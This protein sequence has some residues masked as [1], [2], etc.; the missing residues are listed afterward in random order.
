MG[1]TASTSSETPPPETPSSQA[2][3][4]TIKVEPQ[5]ASPYPSREAFL[6]PPPELSPTSRDRSYTLMVTEILKRHPSISEKLAQTVVDQ[7]GP[8]RHGWRKTTRRSFYV[9]VA[10]A[11]VA[12]MC[13]A[14]AIGFLTTLTSRG[15]LSSC[16]RAVDDR[17]NLGSPP[18]HQSDVDGVVR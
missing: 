8:I 14:I 7:Q 16:L 10:L 1:D 2:T 11:L 6:V 13:A 15:R 18:W 4:P 17:A 9:V 3:A 5:S 12:V